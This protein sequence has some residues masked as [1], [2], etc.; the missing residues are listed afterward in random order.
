M[1]KKL[2]KYTQ[3]KSKN[4]GKWTKFNTLEP[5]AFQVKQLK[6]YKYKLR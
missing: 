2:K 1:A 6:K 4:T 5:V 3:Y